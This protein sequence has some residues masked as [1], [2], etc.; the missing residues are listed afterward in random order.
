ML[1]LE[2]AGYVK[3]SC[4]QMKV[5]QELFMNQKLIFNR[6]IKGAVVIAASLLTL[7]CSEMNLDESQSNGLS[8]LKQNPQ[9]QLVPYHNKSVVLAVNIA[10]SEYLGTDGILYQADEL[11]VGGQRH[12]L[13]N[14]KGSQDPALYQT[15]QSG[16]FSLSHPL[17]NGTYSITLKFAEPSDEP[18]GNRVFNVFAQ[19]QKVIN[20]LDIKLARDGKGFSSLDRTVY[21]VEVT[22]GHL[23]IAFE[24]ITGEPV[25]SAIIV[26][27]VFVDERSWQLVWHDEFE[28]DGAPDPS[29][30]NYDIWA[31]KK[32][33]DED[34]TYTNRSKNVRIEN[35]VLVIEAHKEQFNEAEYTSAR[36]NSL[37]KGDF[38][39]GKADVRAKIPA[40][41]GTWS[42][43]WM[44]PSDP[45]RYA[46]TCEEGEDWQG[47]STCDAWPNSGEIDIMEH[48]GY[49]MNRVHGTVHNKAYYWMNWEQRKASI[50]G[51]NVDQ[52]FHV[53]SVEWTPDDVTVYFNDIPYFYYKNEKSGWRAWPFDHPY[54]IILNLAIGGAWGRSGGPIDDSLFPVKME[55][56]YVRVYSLSDQ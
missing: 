12:T 1:N 35:G 9:E 26:R 28:T 10:G 11:T 13:E 37:D 49:D 52:Q 46:T 16:Q 3:R 8:Q 2:S 14:I 38:L 40:G 54:H 20:R 44:L 53:Y 56:D 4:A 25:L 48:V 30:W 50:E 21:D 29:K 45:F 17:E 32:V 22:K 27:K 31:A 19:Q 15:Y 39:Y 55:V 5:C 51:V 6:Y 43:I 42:A 18:T 36:L 34:Q 41:Q 7:S 47:S 23:N 24:A 33:N